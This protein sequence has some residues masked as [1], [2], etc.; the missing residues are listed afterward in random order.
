[1]SREKKGRNTIV[2]R[3][4]QRTIR[5]LK[6]MLRHGITYYDPRAIRPSRSLQ[7]LKNFIYNVY[8]ICGNEHKTFDIC[9]HI[10]FILS[11]LDAEKKFGL[12]VSA[13]NIQGILSR[14]L[15]NL[16]TE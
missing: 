7:S 8:R 1:L 11:T 13:K 6:E 9:T 15:K 3:H 16:S 14:T 2:D 4:E 10:S 5:S 12:K